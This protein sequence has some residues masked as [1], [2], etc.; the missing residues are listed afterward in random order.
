MTLGSHTGEPLTDLF[1]TM[2]AV[3]TGLTNLG[4]KTL[5]KKLNKPKDVGPP[6]C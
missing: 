2:C 5:Q 4:I 1:K 6:V 3:I